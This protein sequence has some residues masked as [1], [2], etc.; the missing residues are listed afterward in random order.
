MLY[1]TLALYFLICKLV[2]IALRNSV[3]YAYRSAIVLILSKTTLMR[4][5]K[6]FIL[7]F[8]V[9]YPYVVTFVGIFVYRR[10]HK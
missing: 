9:K 8:R 1:V 6:S 10:T 5:W 3:I 7:T 4:F 2:P